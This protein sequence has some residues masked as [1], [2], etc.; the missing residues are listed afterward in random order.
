MNGNLISNSTFGDRI[1]T[2][3]EKAGYNTPRELAL[4]LCGYTKTTKG[5]M[6]EDGKRVDL[7]R[8][9][10]QNWEQGKN[11]PNVHMVANLCNLLDCDPDYL[12]YEDRDYPRKEIKSAADTVGLSTEAV[13][14]LIGITNLSITRKPFS[15]SCGL[16]ISTMLENPHFYSIIKTITETLMQYS[17]L[18]YNEAKMQLIPPNMKE[19]YDIEIQGLKNDIEK[20]S[21]NIADAGFTIIDI[22]NMIKMLEFETNQSV[23]SL[24]KETLDTLQEYFS[25]LLQ[26]EAKRIKREYAQ[27]AYKE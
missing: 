6:N 24:V 18:E 27:S 2:L 20:I 19:E 25:E 17:V 4:V 14:M 9:N 3:R 7:M 1:C 22:K 12:L 11:I 23:S 15:M 13:K 16:I 10:I 26:A 8:R 5:L 21:K